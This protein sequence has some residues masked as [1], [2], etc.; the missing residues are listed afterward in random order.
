M[1]FVVTCA[2]CG[3]VRLDGWVEPGETVRR[4]Q[5]SI[6][7][8]TPLVSH[9]ICDRCFDQRVPREAESEAA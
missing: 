3:R 4:L 9:G 7:S 1:E 8:C 2:W 6:A 5:P